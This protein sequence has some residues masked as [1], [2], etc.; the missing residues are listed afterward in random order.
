MSADHPA[1]I[2]Q[3]PS[4]GQQSASRNQ[5][6]SVSI[7]NYY[8]DFEAIG[9][10]VLKLWGLAIIHSSLFFWK[11]K[12]TAIARKFF[13]KHFYLIRHDRGRFFADELLDILS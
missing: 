13:D 12:M 5:H 7:S 4:D 3:V 2:P 10:H 6:S 1:D 9:N 11:S 8:R